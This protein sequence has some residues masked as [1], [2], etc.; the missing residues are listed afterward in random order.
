MSDTPSPAELHDFN[1]TIIEEF[2][3]N[4]GVVG[5][6]FEGAT[7]VLLTTTGAKSGQQRTNPLA[8]YS[9]D[10]RLFVIASKGGAPTHPAWFHNI[11]A[12]PAV[13]VEHGS[14]TYD[15]TATVVG[16]QRDALF[17]RIAAA[18]PAF[19][20]YQQDLDRIIPVVEI[21]RR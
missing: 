4:G 17:G 3:A 11:T 9:E 7:L 19:G 20:E 6:P 1:S 15:T 13:T 10:G 16:E 18:M 2:R 12:N 5:G 14:E 8:S 21:T